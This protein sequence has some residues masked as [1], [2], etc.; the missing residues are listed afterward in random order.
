V[1]S[2][3]SRVHK[4]PY[5]F[6]GSNTKGW[7]CSGLVRWTYTHFGLEVPHSANKQAHIG[8][9]VSKP[10]VGDIV[11][12]AYKGS[13]NF[14]HSAIYAGQN[15]VVNA[16]VMYGTTVLEPLSNYSKSQIRFVRVVEQ[17]ETQR[18]MN[19]AQEDLQM[20]SAVPQDIMS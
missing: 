6:S 3:I 7:D 8:K 12:F 1:K 17:Q 2:L 5:V 20:E 18:L 19:Q 10:N 14:Y 15:I 13:K 11:V 9:R 16:N 4:T